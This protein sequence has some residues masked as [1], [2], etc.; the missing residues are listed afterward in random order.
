MEQASGIDRLE[1]ALGTVCQSLRIP[2]PALRARKQG[3]GKGVSMA[4]GME[5][6]E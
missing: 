2:A 4:D 1:A 5:V 6:I 3:G